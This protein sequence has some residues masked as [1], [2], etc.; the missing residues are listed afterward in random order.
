MLYLSHLKHKPES[1]C[2]ADMNHCQGN[3]NNTS[4]KKKKKAML[5]IRFAFLLLT[6]LLTL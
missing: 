4:F 2:G 5:Y 6:Q 3:I 1:L